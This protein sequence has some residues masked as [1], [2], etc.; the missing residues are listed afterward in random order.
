M[1]L[2]GLEIFDSQ[3]AVESRLSSVD[4]AACLLRI[5]SSFDQQPLNHIR[6][7]CLQKNI[8][9]GLDFS[10]LD[11]PAIRDFCEKSLGGDDVY[12]WGERLTNQEI[13]FGAFSM[14]EDMYKPWNNIDNC[15][16][17][18]ST[19]SGNALALNKAK[20]TLLAALP[21]SAD[22]LNICSEIEASKEKKKKYFSAFVNPNL[23]KFYQMAGYNLEIKEAFG[24]HLTLES[25]D[26][27]KPEKLLDCLSG[28]ALG[29]FGH[30]PQDLTSSV[31]SVHDPARDY[32]AE[33]SSELS[34]LTGFESIFPAVSGAT[35]V[36]IGMYLA[37]LSQDSPRKK[38]IVFSD[39]YSGKLL[40]PAIASPSA[41]QPNHYFAPLYQ[42]VVIDVYSE[43]ASDQ[44]LA[45]IHSGEVA[46]IWFEYLRGADGEKLPDYL[47]DIILQNR[48]TYGYYIG[49]DEILMGLY[50]SGPL[51]S[52]QR[53]SLKPDIVTLSKALSY[54]SFPIGATLVRSGI[55]EKARANAPEYVD[56]MKTRYAN[57]LGA[58][59]ALH[60]LRKLQDEDIAGNVQKQAEYLATR[61]EKLRGE[62]NLIE[63]IEMAGLYFGVHFKKPRWLKLL[64]PYRE[65]LY[66][67]F[68]TKCWKNA[69]VFAFFDTR[70]MP[71]LCLSEQEADQFLISTKKMMDLHPWKVLATGLSRT[72]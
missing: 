16:L 39:N 56:Q 1:L 41:A 15:L 54:M 19:Y 5:K 21:W 69:G 22:Q 51:F 6:Q 43:K 66:L 68:L 33:L 36:E 60:C 38:I 53:T 40:L 35:A 64:G 27:E 11:L 45:E 57:Q 61:L 17:H 10:D 58:H 44:L 3:E 34:R 42:H 55:Y 65:F 71:S 4:A 52:F 49:V 20:E 48:E 28:G 30:N 26:G 62:S 14:S 18:S 32:W 9:L 59:I 50:R 7:I 23:G 37:L 2:P 13:P 24:C 12:I 63:R 8:R 25:T 70:L 31:L 47:V 46:L 67:L 29:V 72:A